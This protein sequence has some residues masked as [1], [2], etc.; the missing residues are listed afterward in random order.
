MWFYVRKRD[1]LWMM[2]KS[3]FTRDK[4]PAFVKKRKGAMKTYTEAEVNAATDIKADGA[5]LCHDNQG[6]IV[7]YTGLFQWKDG[8]VRDEPDPTYDT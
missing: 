1:L 5:E 8:T 2:V 4:K 7:L 3:L 6:Q